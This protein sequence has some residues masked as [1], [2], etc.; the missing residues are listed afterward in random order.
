MKFI[1][2]FAPFI[3][4]C[5][6]S[7]KGQN[8]ESSCRVVCDPVVQTNQFSVPGKHGPKGD[9]GEPGLPGSDGIDVEC[10]KKIENLEQMIRKVLSI[11]S[12][13]SR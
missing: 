4:R 5:V 1:L 3:L 9:K 8:C 11:D 10:R 13:A 7:V 12:L 6:I 2:F